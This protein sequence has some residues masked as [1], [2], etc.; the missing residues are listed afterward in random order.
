ML[1]RQSQDPLCNLPGH[2]S[3]IVKI[4]FGRLPSNDFRAEPS[5]SARAGQ[6][7]AEN[8]ALLG[9]NQAEGEVDALSDLALG[10]GHAVFPKT[11]GLAIH[12]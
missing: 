12:Q 11:L 1:R 6:C 9:L 7:F 8:F 4:V 5:V 10:L 2:G 3:S